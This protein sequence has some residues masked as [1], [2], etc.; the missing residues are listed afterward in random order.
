MRFRPLFAALLAAG[1]CLLNVPVADAGWDRRPSGWGKE[2]E[3]KHWVYYPRYRHKYKY[4]P[5][6]DPYAYQYSPRGYYPYYNSHY[7]RPA[8]EMR[9]KRRKYTY[10][11][12][13]YFQAW[14]YPM[15]NYRHREWH[16]RHYG[17]HRKHHW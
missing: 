2:R 12:P 9:M 6:T 8:W 3:V 14:G 4:H 10:V 5:Y 16:H 1:L 17:G 11:Y 13:P 15:R 7:W